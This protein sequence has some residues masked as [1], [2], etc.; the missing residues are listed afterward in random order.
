MT[1]I[2]KMTLSN[3]VLNSMEDYFVKLDGS[4]TTDLY[5]LV[6][7]EIEDPLFRSVMKHTKNNQSNAA[8]IL[9]ISR[10]TLRK[11]IKQYNI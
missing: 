6:L 2:K 3:H 11:K 4:Q 9:G 10:V 8:S 7:K 1:E 5:N